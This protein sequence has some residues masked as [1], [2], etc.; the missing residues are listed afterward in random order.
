MWP[1]DE[2]KKNQYKVYKGTW[3]NAKM[4]GIG[5]LTM[6]EG[7][8]YIGEFVNGYPIGHGVRKWTNGD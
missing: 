4:Q 7:E 8:I 2:T 1:T 5:E 3:V 6:S